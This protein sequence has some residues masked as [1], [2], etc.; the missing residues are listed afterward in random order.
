MYQIFSVR[1]KIKKKRKKEMQIYIYVLEKT[2]GYSYFHLQ[3][4]CHGQMFHLINSLT[5]IY[6]MLDISY[7]Y[8]TSAWLAEQ[9]QYK[10]VHGQA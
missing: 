8:L 5:P 4:D 7:P 3:F 2:V 1:Q 10:A 9:I 6:V